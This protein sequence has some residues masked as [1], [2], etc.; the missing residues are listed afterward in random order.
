MKKIIS[1]TCFLLILTLTS[2]QE[3]EEDP[4]EIEKMVFLEDEE[5]QWTIENDF[6]LKA[7]AEENTPLQQE[8]LILEK[9]GSP[10][11]RLEEQETAR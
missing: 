10:L 11:N 2:C 8:T 4:S 5:E 1:I 6:D 3:K 9:G 7:I